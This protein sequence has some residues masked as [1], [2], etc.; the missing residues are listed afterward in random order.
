MVW[1]VGLNALTTAENRIV[2][3]FV[4]HKNAKLFWDADAHYVE[5]DKHEGGLFLRQH[6]QQWGNA[7][8]V[9]FLKT[10]KL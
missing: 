5:N 10:I 1:F 7:K 4:T 8:L 6:F 3:H 9:A 2:N